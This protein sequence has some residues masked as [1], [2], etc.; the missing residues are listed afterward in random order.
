M[1]PSPWC[2]LERYLQIGSGVVGFIAA[3]LWLSSAFALAPKSQRLNAKAAFATGIAV[4][5]QFTTAFTPSCW[6]G[7][8]F[9]AH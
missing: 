5:L 2:E 7:M 1:P 8:P 6:S 9:V 4:L 3:A